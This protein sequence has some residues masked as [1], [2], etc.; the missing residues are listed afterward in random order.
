MSHRTLAAAALRWYLGAMPS[1]EPDV[2]LLPA[3]ASL[4]PHW[5]RWRGQAQ[6]VLHN[7]FDPLSELELA[8]RLTA[9]R[10]DL[11]G[12]LAGEHRWA[13]TMDGRPVGTCALGSISLRMQTAEVSYQVDEAQHGRGIATRAV[14]QLVEQVFAL[15]PLHRLYAYVAEDNR[16]SC[17]VLEKLGFQPEGRLREH[18]IV[19]GRRTTERVFGRLRSDEV[20][21]S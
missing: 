20:S 15:T 1:P 19:N 8:V 3:D 17:R 9:C 2:Q 11:R 7:P 12:D 4:A 6:A 5:E 18:Y 16:A 10:S 13:I 14:G 21:R